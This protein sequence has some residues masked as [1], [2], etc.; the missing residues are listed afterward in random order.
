VHDKIWFCG[1]QA[2]DVQKNEGGWV[3]GLKF[4]VA[5]CKLG[6]MEK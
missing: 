4:C 5:E 3:C 6:C 1:V 2:G